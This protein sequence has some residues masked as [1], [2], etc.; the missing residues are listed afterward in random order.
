M[1][2]KWRRDRIQWQWKETG[3]LIYPEENLICSHDLDVDCKRVSITGN[4]FNVFDLATR[5]IGWQFSMTQ[6]IV[7]VFSCED[8]DSL[9]V[10]GAQ[11]LIGS[12]TIKKCGFV[13]VSMAF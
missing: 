5:I 6:K 9:N 3:L 11:N 13:R 2:V 10:T 4:Q 12:G 8:C 7:Y 1:K